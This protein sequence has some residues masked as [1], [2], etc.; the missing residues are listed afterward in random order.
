MYVPAGPMDPGGTV[1]IGTSAHIP[2]H[3]AVIIVLHEIGHCLQ[4]QESVDGLYGVTMRE[5]QLAV[6]LDADRRA[7]DLACGLHL[8]GVALLRELFEYAQKEFDYEGDYLHGT[9]GERISQGE[10]ALSCRVQPRQAS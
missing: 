9:R 2:P 1:Y 6:E 8:D 5:G 3:L 10:R 4:D 7:A